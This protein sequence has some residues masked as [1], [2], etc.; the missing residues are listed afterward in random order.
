[1]NDGQRLTDELE[2]T[3]RAELE[4]RLETLNG[5]LLELEQG[6]S[7]AR[8]R[9]LL[10]S[11]FRDMHSLKGGAQLVGKSDLA[12]VAHAAEA[13]LAGSGAMRAVSDAALGPLFAAVGTLGRLAKGLPLGSGEVERVVAGF[14]A[15]TA[16]H[17]AEDRPELAADGLGH[18]LMSDVD[19][20]SGDG[21]GGASGDEGARA[22]A[23]GAT[24][25]VSAE[26]LDA[27]LSRSGEL[28][29]ARDLAVRQERRIKDLAGELAARQQRWAETGSAS[30]QLGRGL[31]D[32]PLRR[33]LDEVGGMQAGL[34]QAE[35]EARAVAREARVA[36]QRF[37]QLV[38]QLEAELR[39]L[40]M[41]P[42]A[43]LFRP[44]SRM[45]RDLG[46]SMSKPVRL[47]GIGWDTPI[48]REL[49]ERLKDPVMH[50]LRNA[51]DHGIEPPETRSRRGKPASGSVTLEARREGD[52]LVIEVR[53]D[54]GGID[55]GQ[56]LE[57]AA[58]NGS[59][60]AEPATDGDAA[61]HAIFQ[62]GFSTLDAPSAVSGRGVGLDVVATQ[63]GAL[64]GTIGVRS[65]DSGTAFTLRLPLTLIS[66]RVLMIRAGE[67]RYAL[68]IDAIQRVFR[69]ESR[70]VVVHGGRQTINVD[71]RPHVVADLAATLGLPRTPFDE[72]RPLVGLLTGSAG[73]AVAFVVTAVQGEREVVVKPLGQPVGRT[74]LVAGAA[75]V[76]QDEVV[77]VLDQA[78]LTA[79]ATGVPSSR[80]APS[81]AATERRDADRPLR[82][83]V[84]DD[85]ITTRTLEKNILSAAGFE[86]ALAAD[87]RDA[88]RSVR[89]E[90]FDL[91]VSDVDM[92]RMTGLEL[93][94]AMR[95]DERL[96][97]VPVIIV[98]YKDREEDRLRG[99]DLG[100]NYY[101][102]KSSFHDNTFLKA[103][104][105]LI[106]EA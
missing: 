7:K 51:V 79:S 97:D 95:D 27:L 82:V 91:V 68:P 44:F 77:L 13:H 54:G 93:V 102:T 80:L 88:L 89:L 61:L 59:R 106:G 86:V 67:S 11:L 15:G 30:R 41:V 60:G 47:H 28:I 46:L 84:A 32:G 3:F 78:A 18:E 29:A 16:D 40:R 66:T 103:V 12:A 57:R 104:A 70:E 26:R 76:D 64:G 35:H 43:R 94:K 33:V 53:D 65:D 19:G 5:A 99:L 50:L 23:P 2:E 92:P 37:A 42:V 73:A 48:D 24:V 55:R 85:S 81:S 1:M 49:L 71:G 105:D 38:D 98:S 22:S 4:E 39:D 52:R 36:A 87:G 9:E 21:V 96:R 10:D 6:V 83:L 14:R 56:V 34:A 63:V 31:P 62:A 74:P 100:A 45:V 8:G 20:A 90:P 25:R 72:G 58:A 17:A 101:L 69:F 75:L